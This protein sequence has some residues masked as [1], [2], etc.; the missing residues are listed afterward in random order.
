MHAKLFVELGEDVELRLAHSAA[1]R[2]RANGGGHRCASLQARK[3]CQSP[4]VTAGIQGFIAGSLG[5]SEFTQL[6]HDLCLS[7]RS[8]SGDSKE[9]NR[10]LQWCR[11]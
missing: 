6:S 7:V 8:I 2:P 1:R 5:Y 11:G 9:D 3:T 10:S 4:E